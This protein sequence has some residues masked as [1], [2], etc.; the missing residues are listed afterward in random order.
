MFAG[1]ALSSKFLYPTLQGYKSKS[2]R[3]KILV[4]ISHKKLSK[5]LSENFTL[6]QPSEVSPILA[7]R[8]NLVPYHDWLLLGDSKNIIHG[9]FNFATVRGRKTREIKRD[10]HFVA[11]SYAQE[12]VLMCVRCILNQVPYLIFKAPNGKKE[13]IPT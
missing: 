1:W 6:I 10:L 7:K 11:W 9:P 8:R 13:D 5:I 3:T 12:L 2:N 4:G